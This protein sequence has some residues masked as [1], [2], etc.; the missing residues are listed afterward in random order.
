MPKIFPKGCVVMS[1]IK[2]YFICRKHFKLIDKKIKSPLVR[3]LLKTN[4][5]KNL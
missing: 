3:E 1:F 4:F 5:A 2:K